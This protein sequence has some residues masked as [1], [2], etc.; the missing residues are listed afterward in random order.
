M[1]NTYTEAEYTSVSV[2]VTAAEARS[3]CFRTL[4]Y[5]GAPEPLLVELPEGL[6]TGAVLYVD[7][8]FFVNYGDIEVRPLRID[9]TV[10]KPRRGYGAAAALLFVASAALIVILVTFARDARRTPTVTA[11]PAPVQARKAITG[12]RGDRSHRPWMAAAPKP[13]PTS[14][15]SQT[16]TTRARRRAEKTAMRCSVWTSSSSSTG[17]SRFHSTSAS[18]ASSR[19]TAAGSSQTQDET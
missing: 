12:S 17:A 10:Q 8:P 15:T 2:S 7:A 19:R 6:K 18:G 11:T 14:S 16:P 5:P 3:G 4:R 9:V 13:S 1:S